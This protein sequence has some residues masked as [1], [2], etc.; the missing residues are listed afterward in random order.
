MLSSTGSVAAVSV[1][2]SAGVLLSLPL[3][4]VRSSAAVAPTA[5]TFTVRDRDHFMPYPL[6]RLWVR[7]H[8]RVW[9]Q[10][11]R[12]QGQV[13]QQWSG[14]DLHRVAALDTGGGGL[15]RGGLVGHLLV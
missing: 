8:L 9:V 2:S 6:W 3:H 1:V 14:G 13:T 12:Q 4:A 15:E 7:S 5:K 10:L 11:V